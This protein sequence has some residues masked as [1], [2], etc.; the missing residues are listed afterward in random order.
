MTSWERVKH[1]K[2]HLFTQLV[3]EAV[4]YFYDVPS[5]MQLTIWLRTA[6][7]IFLRLR[8]LA[9]LRPEE[10]IF[11]KYSLCRRCR[12][13]SCFRCRKSHIS[14]YGL[15]VNISIMCNVGS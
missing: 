1:T 11:P 14:T 10:C 4:L 6:W 9:E 15:S 2:I 12:I 8:W 7:C 3:A 5:H 13:H